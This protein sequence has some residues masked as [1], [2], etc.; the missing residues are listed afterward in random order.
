MYTL[1]LSRGHF[2]TPTTDNRSTGFKNPLRG[3]ANAGA[4][5]ISENISVLNSLIIEILFVFV[6]FWWLQCTFWL[7]TNS[8]EQNLAY[9]LS[10]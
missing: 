4:L 6:A 9:F 7:E 10:Q 8:A 5:I 3:F 2:L 1:S